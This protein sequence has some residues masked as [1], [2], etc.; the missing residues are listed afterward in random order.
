MRARASSDFSNSQSEGLGTRPESPVWRV[1]LDLEKIAVATMSDTTLQTPYGPERRPW[2]ETLSPLARSPHDGRLLVSA[3][4][5]DPLQLESYSSA[6]GITNSFY[7]VP[8]TGL[9]EEQQASAHK[10][11]IAF[12]RSRAND[13]LG[14]QTN[15]SL[16]HLE[17]LKDY[18]GMHLNNVGDPFRNGSYLVN[19]KWMER[20]VLDYYASLWNA[21][22]PH[23]PNDKESYWGYVL[24]MGATEGNL[25]GLWNARDYLSGKFMMSETPLEDNGDT[26]ENPPPSDYVYMQGRCP[27]DNPNAL[28]PVAFYSEDSHYSIFKALQ[29]LNFPSF[30]EVGVEKYPN[31]NPLGGNWP[32]QVPSKDGDA[33]PG[34]VDIEALEKLVDFFS[35]KG[36]PILVIFNYGTT[37]KGAYDDVKAAGESLVRIIEKNG[38]LDR[39]IF[40]NLDDPSKYFIRRGYWFHVDGAL[41]ASYMR[42][43]EM[44]YEN[45]MIKEKPGPIFDFRLDFVCSIVTSAHKWIGAPWPCGVYLTRSS[46]QLRSPSDIS[47]LETPDTTFAGSRSG[48]NVAVLWTYIST[49]SYEK[50]VKKAIHTMEVAAYAEQKLKELGMEIRQ[51]LWVTRSPLSLTVR[52]KKANDEVVNKYSLSNETLY[53]DGHHREYSHIYIMENIDREKLD[54]FIDDLRKPGAFKAPDSQL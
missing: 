51:D 46:L 11:T 14:F 5:A 39:K 6:R 47:F 18:L 29:V 35:S 33:G 15:M 23:D 49:H 20:N 42:F 52:F 44:A 43:I 19:T 26:A 36:Y 31:E 37:F 1:D 13:M 27:P 12:T 28:T 7:Q 34:S 32:K 24:T 8:S 22:W 41:G 2:V 17:V 40:Y 50:Q 10:E 53:I 16:D 38:M 9:T 30:Y 21:K 25:Y 45:G 3:P 48:I 4:T 54:R